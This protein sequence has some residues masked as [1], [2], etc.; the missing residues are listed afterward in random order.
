VTT[1]GTY[2]FNPALSDVVL[3]AFAR[4]GLHRSALGTEHYRD[5][6]DE[7]NYLLVEWSNKQP[8]LWTSATQ[9]LALVAGT[10][11]YSLLPQTV[12]VLIAYVRSG[13]GVNTSDKLIGPVSTTEY[14]AIPNKFL[15]AE[16][17]LFWFDRQTTPAVTVWPT[18]NTSYSMIVRTVRQVQDAS[19]PSGVTVEVPYRF[20]DAFTAG[21]AARLARMYAPTLEAERKKDALDAWGIAAQQ[22]VENVPLYI[23]PGLDSYFR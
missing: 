3:N 8:L 7:A 11:T 16:P 21:L 9:T 10:A 17:T 19:L 2:T 5:A 15:Q 4:V 23:I 6:A 13:A 12:M 20:L 1:S 14:E 22:D 18:P